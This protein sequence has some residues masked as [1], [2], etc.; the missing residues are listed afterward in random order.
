VVYEDLTPKRWV[1]ADNPLDRIRPSAYLPVISVWKS[2]AAITFVVDNTTVRSTFYDQLRRCCPLA[3]DANN[4]K[5]RTNVSIR[6]TKTVIVATQRRWQKRRSKTFLSYSKS[7][8]LFF[9]PPAILILVQV[10]LGESITARTES[11]CPFTNLASR[12]HI[13]TLKLYFVASF[14]E[15]GPPDLC[16]V[17][18]STG[19]SG[20]RDVRQSL[21]LPIEALSLIDIIAWFLPLH[22]RCRCILIC[23]SRCIHQLVDLRYRG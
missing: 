20:Q 14:R 12:A 7:G 17:V 13:F 3:S 16:H 10:E 22:L 4:V 23:I 15:L 18:K 1:I 6:A 8:F 2:D 9:E 21:R 19:R 5:A 11:L